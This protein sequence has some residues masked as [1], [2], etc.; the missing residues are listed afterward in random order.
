MDGWMDRRTDRQTDRE[1]L[2]FYLAL[3]DK[4]Q[5]HTSI[6]PLR[7]PSIF[8][9]S[10]LYRAVGNISQGKNILFKINLVAF[11]VVPENVKP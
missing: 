4:F 5:T 9:S 3:K 6:K 8:F 1:F 11:L 10:S 7:P 2:K